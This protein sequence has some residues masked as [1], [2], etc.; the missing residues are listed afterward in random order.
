MD[1]LDVMKSFTSKMIGS[2]GLLVFLKHVFLI[3]LLNTVCVF[4]LL[5]CPCCIGKLAINAMALQD[6]VLALHFDG[7]LTTMFGYCL[8]ATFLFVVHAVSS[9][10]GLGSYKQFIWHCYTVIKVRYI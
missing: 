4:L 10:I 5:L 7:L 2:K 9:F 1:D 8:I 6:K 3:I